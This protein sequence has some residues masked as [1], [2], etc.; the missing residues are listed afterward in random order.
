MDKVGVFGRLREVL[1]DFRTIDSVEVIDCDGRLLEV[2]E[3]WVRAFQV[4]AH[5]ASDEE[6]EWIKENFKIYSGPK[7]H[8]L[9]ILRRDGKFENEFE[10]GFFD[11][12]ANMAFEIL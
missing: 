10:G 6:F 2:D 9:M 12:N 3:P 7:R 11:G 1:R 5:N 8:E 4:V